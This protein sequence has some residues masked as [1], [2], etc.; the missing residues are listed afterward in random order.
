MP[1]A[2]LRE[3]LMLDQFMSSGPSIQELAALDLQQQRAPLEQN[4]LQEQIRASQ[5]RQELMPREQLLREQQFAAE[6][7]LAQQGLK[8]GLARDA[9]LERQGDTGLGL[10]SD[11]NAMR[12]MAMMLGIPLNEARTE[13][14]QIQNQ[15][16]R[17]MLERLLGQPT[18]GNNMSPE[19]EGFLTQLLMHFQQG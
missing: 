7:E 19:E 8:R 17:P 4:L 16:Y 3:L 18:Q 13:Q 11:Q 15:I 2:D 9:V 12:E 5:Q 1:K 14:L 6:Q 10:Q